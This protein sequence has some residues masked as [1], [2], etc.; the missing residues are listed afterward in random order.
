MRG[1]GGSV[2]GGQW[3][4]CWFW[5][6]GG[7]PFACSVDCLQASPRL[8]FVTKWYL[9]SYRPLTSQISFCALY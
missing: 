5:G 6:E 3:A 9:W 4:G 8:I 1:E 7:W 2:G